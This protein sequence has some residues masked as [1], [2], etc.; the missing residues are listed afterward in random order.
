MIGL[1]ICCSEN[2]ALPV[3]KIFSKPVF[4][5][6]RDIKRGHILHLQTQITLHLPSTVHKFKIRIHKCPTLTTPRKI[7]FLIRFLHLP[8]FEHFKEIN[9]RH[10]LSGVEKWSD[11]TPHGHLNIFGSMQCRHFIRCKSYDFLGSV[12][13]QELFFSEAK[14]DI[15]LSGGQIVCWACS[16]NLSLLPSEL[17]VIHLVL[18]SW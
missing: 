9:D 4:V 11:M 8:V 14:H 5:Q 10:L 3:Q 16:A 6:L 12:K 1:V 17:I 15:T 7:K 18:G 2:K 13:G